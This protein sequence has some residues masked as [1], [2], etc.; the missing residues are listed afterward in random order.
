MTMIQCIFSVIFSLYFVF[1]FVGELLMYGFE[2]LF[3]LFLLALGVA[4]GVAL[5]ML[6][7][8]EYKHGDD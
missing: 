4:G 8:R 1:L 2:R 3:I 6:F 5:I 7:Y